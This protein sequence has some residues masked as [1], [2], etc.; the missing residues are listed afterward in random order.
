MSNMTSKLKN[1]ASSRYTIGRDVFAKIS[2][3]EDIRLTS[4]MDE[5]F[6]EFERKGLTAEERRKAI[7][8][9]YGRSR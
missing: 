4:E 7:A 1:G 2:E 3:V 5:D 6:R 9:K 8:A